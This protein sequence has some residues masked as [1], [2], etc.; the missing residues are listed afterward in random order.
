MACGGQDRRSRTKPSPPLIVMVHRTKLMHTAFLSVSSTQTI[1]YTIKV[2]FCIFR[3]F[4]FFSKY[5]ISMQFL[6]LFLFLALNFGFV[7]SKNEYLSTECII[8]NNQFY[9]LKPIEPQT[10]NERKRN[11][12]RENK[13]KCVQM[14]T[15]TAKNVTYGQNADYFFTQNDMRMKKEFFLRFTYWPRTQHKMCIQWFVSLS[16]HKRSS[17]QQCI[18]IRLSRRRSLT[19]STHIACGYRFLILFFHELFARC[20]F[21]FFFIDVVAVAAGVFFSRKARLDMTN[22]HR[23]YLQN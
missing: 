12:H 14:N 6:L 8:G 15:L 11:H 22:L 9:H 5:L 2:H 10:S 21:R 18:H 19:C 17:H 13:M 7:F 16:S 20:F 1:I 3:S 23:E 4:F